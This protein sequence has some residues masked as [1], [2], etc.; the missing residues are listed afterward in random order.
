MYYSLSPFVSRKSPIAEGAYNRL[1]KQ[2]VKQI[3]ATVYY[4][5]CI[6]LHDDVDEIKS[7]FAQFSLANP[8][9][10]LRSLFVVLAGRKRTNGKRDKL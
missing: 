10:S 4:K 2:I 7:P 6:E 3:V 5:N 1:V 8:S 9:R